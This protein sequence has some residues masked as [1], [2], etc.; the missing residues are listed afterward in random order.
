[1]I[2]LE[3][4]NN[5]GMKVA[6]PPISERVPKIALVTPFLKITVPVGVPASIDAAFTVAVRV[7]DWPKTDGLALDV[8]L[9]VVSA[10]F[11]ICITWDELTSK[12]P[13][14]LYLA[15]IVCEPTDNDEV[16]KVAWP[17]LSGTVADVVAPSRKS[18]VPVTVLP[19]VDAALTVAVKVTDWVKADGLALD[20]KLV[21][22]SNL[23]TV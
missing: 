1:M 3:P 13:S 9:V 19:P 10:L 4:T 23:S 5:S 7:T 20:V 15:K 2:V 11:T 17:P 8:K 16:V 21:V 12:L 14:P 18:T 22:V 6:W